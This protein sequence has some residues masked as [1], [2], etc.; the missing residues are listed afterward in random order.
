MRLHMTKLGRQAALAEKQTAVGD[1]PAADPG[2]DGQIE[3]VA[4]AS[5]GAIFAARRGPPD[6]RRS[7][8]RP[9]SRRRWLSRS[10]SGKS[11]Q[12]GQVGRVEHQ[13]AIGIERTGRPDAD[14]FGARPRREHR[15]DRLDDPV[16]DRFRALAR[17]GVGILCCAVAGG[18]ACGIVGGA[19][20]RAAEING[21]DRR[22]ARSIAYLLAVPPSRT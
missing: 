14:P 11:T 3:Q 8:W 12:P 9:G 22:H 2:A 10:R 19:S 5:P 4:G 21:N 20:A 1:H 6:W 13:A 18:S 7:R 16:E 17:S 15:L